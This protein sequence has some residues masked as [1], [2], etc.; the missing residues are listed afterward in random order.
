MHDGTKL[1][2]GERRCKDLAAVPRTTRKSVRTRR[3]EHASDSAERDT[4]MRCDVQLV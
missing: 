3:H 2:E 1:V 4:D